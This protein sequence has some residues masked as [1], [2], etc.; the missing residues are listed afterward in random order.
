MSYAFNRVKP[1]FSNN[2]H[3]TSVALS[4]LGLAKIDEYKNK[5]KLTDKVTYDAFDP[6]PEQ[7]YRHLAKY[8]KEYLQ[9]K[10]IDVGSRSSELL[11]RLTGVRA[12]LVDKHNKDLPD[13]DWEK[14]PVPAS[15]SSYQSVICYDT[16]EHIDNFHEGFSDIIRLSSE[17][18]LVSLPNNWKKA[19]NEMIKGRG[20]WESYGIPPEKPHDRH[21]WFFNTEDAEDFIYYHSSRDKLNYEVIDVRYN[22][23]KTILRIKLMYPLLKLLLPEYQFKNLFV[24]T[25][26]FVLKRK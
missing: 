4:D 2:K 11:E 20:R 17:Y 3:Y 13:W 10:V 6:R 23:P 9:G 22:V 8:H 15:D 19:V 25:I 14:T 7:R 26:F 5:F 21:K 1:R 16:L 18:V 12:E 24:E